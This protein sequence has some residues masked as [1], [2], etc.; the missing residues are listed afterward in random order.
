MTHVAITC[1]NREICRKTKV[2]VTRAAGGP[3]P[4]QAIIRILNAPLAVRRRKAS[5]PENPLGHVQA[6]VEGLVLD[7]ADV[8]PGHGK[9]QQLDGGC[10]RAIHSR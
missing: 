8:E 6:R 9:P 10:E 5:G 7:A 2:L 1:K 4:T 3:D